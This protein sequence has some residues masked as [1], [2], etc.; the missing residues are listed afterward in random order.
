[1]GEYF[2]F[3]LICSLVDTRTTARWFQL[4]WMALSHNERLRSTISQYEKES[5]FGLKTI[6]HAKREWSGTTFWDRLWVKHV[7]TSLGST[8]R[9]RNLKHASLY[10]PGLSTSELRTGIWWFLSP[11]SLDGQQQPRLSCAGHTSHTNRFRGV[12]ICV[13]ATSRCIS[14]KAIFT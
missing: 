8:Q 2:Y 6:H 7:W 10:L 12:N 14:F 13:L 4:Y 9:A 11:H 1:M 3:L 5:H